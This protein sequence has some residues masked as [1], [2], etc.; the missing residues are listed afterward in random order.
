MSS[1]L[2]LEKYLD[3]FSSNDHS[4]SKKR[5]EKQMIKQGEPLPLD[6]D[7]ESNKFIF[8]PVTEVVSESFLQGHNLTRQY[9]VSR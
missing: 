1:L 5:E 6:Y 2:F 7:Y 9:V 8:R 3:N 4:Y